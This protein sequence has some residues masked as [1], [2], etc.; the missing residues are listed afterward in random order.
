MSR[1]SW[2]LKGPLKGEEAIANVRVGVGVTV[3]GG[4]RH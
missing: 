4:K 1:T 3:T 2:R